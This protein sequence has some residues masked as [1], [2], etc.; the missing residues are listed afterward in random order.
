MRDDALPIR[1]LLGVGAAI[2]L[3]VAIAIGVVLAILAQRR[4]PLGGAAIDKPL[5]PGP[6]LPM[7]Q[8]APQ[9]D[10]AAYRA[11]K[12]QALHGLGWVDAASGVAHVPI[13]TAM[14][15]QAARAA[16]AGAAR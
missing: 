3:A 1:R 11:E 8:A 14:A 4:V 9:P 15:L 13:E 16:S 6:G 7:L 2:V 12:Q 10:L 5:S